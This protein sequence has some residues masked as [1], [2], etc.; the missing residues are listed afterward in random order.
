MKKQIDSSKE[1]KKLVLGRTRYKKGKWDFLGY[2]I[3][4]KKPA[5]KKRSQREGPVITTSSGWRVP[6][7]DGR[8]ATS[9]KSRNNT[10]FIVDSKGN[11]R[12]VKNK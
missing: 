10:D 11:A 4:K 8:I 5:K 3:T 12:K 9:S 6:L 2:Q 7:Y 1:F